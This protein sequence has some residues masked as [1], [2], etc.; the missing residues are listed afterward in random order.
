MDA[1]LATVTRQLRDR[2]TLLQSRQLTVRPDFENGPKGGVLIGYVADAQLTVHTDDLDGVGRIAAVAL[3]VAGEAG[4][5]HGLH[6]SRLDTEP[7]QSAARDGAFADAESKARR[8]A[9]LAARTLGNL[10]ELSELPI[11]PGDSEVVAHVV[12]TWELVQPE[13]D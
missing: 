5:I 7:A 9:T 8:Y 2:S 1:L 11:E 4:T 6:L 12:G 3:E 10:L 13:Q